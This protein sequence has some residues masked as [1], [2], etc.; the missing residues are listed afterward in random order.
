MKIIRVD[1]LAQRP[2]KAALMSDSS[3][4]PDRRPLFL[5]DGQWSCEIRPAVR[6]DRLGKAVAARFA[7]KYYNSAALVNYLRPAGAEDFRADM[8]DDAIV[9]GKWVPVE[10][11]AE[12]FSFDKEGFDSL[13]EYLSENTT[14]KTGDIIVLPDVIK[15]YAPSI[16]QEINVENLLEF[17]IK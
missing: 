14:F 7:S 17:S 1:S 16:N 8:A 4:R 13:L 9:I 10:D 6:I 11:L 2:L 3:L 5:P 12:H 15:S